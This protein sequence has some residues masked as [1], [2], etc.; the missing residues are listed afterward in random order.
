MIRRPPRSTLFPYTTLFRSHR[1]V[2]LLALV[3]DDV[4]RPPRVRLVAPAMEAVVEA[5]H[6]QEANEPRPG[7]ATGDR[8]QAVMVVEVEG[9]REEERLDAYLEHL[10]EDAAG[11]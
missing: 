9:G 4:G 5:I 7:R 10:V 1:E 6:A 2:V 8:P 11:E 3:V